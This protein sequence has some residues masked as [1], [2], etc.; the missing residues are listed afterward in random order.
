MAELPKA[1]LGRHARLINLVVALL[2]TQRYVTAAWIFEHVAG[3]GGRSRESASRLLYRD[4]QQLAASGIVIDTIPEASIAEPQPGYRILRSDYELPPVQFT[5]AEATA[6]AIAA[7][8]A[9]GTAA[10]E[11]SPAALRHH[12]TL[13]LE[14][15][16]AGGLALPEVLP[17]TVATVVPTFRSDHP[18]LAPVLQALDA[19]KAIEIEYYRSP[20]QDPEW[21]ELEPWGVA[22]VAGE[23]FLA[24]FDRQR[25]GVRVFRLSRLGETVTILDSPVTTALPKGHSVAG[26]V[27]EQ[28]AQLQGSTDCALAIAEGAAPLLRRAASSELGEHAARTADLAEHEDLIVI[29]G[30][31]DN[32][33]ITTIAL[34]PGQV[35]VLAPE[36]I[37]TRVSTAATALAEVAVLDLD[38]QDD[39]EWAG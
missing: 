36:R 32:W 13:A 14:K 17:D 28:L 22:T 21:R 37:A 15:L 19:K 12:I 8:L 23:F 24:G 29:P 9:M 38:D 26:L 18:A 5:D 27:R 20:T 4:R 1:T 16:T 34:Y 2:Q 7:R 33:L 11:E 39:E 35:R 31:P 30:A 6:I 25:V 10:S 3:Y